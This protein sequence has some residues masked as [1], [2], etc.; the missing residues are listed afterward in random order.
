MK[1]FLLIFLLVNISSYAEKCLICMIGN[2]RGT[3]IAWQSFR[4]QVLIPLDADLALCFGQ[5][6]KHKNS[7]YKTAKYLWEIPEYTN[8]ADVFNQA[9]EKYQ[10]KKDWTIAVDATRRSALWGGI[11]HKNKS[12]RG[13]GAVVMA[14]RHILKN[15]ILDNGLLKKYD[16]FIITRS[17]YYYELAH[18]KL[19]NL[20]PNFIWIP[21]GEDYEGI[22]DRHAVVSKEHVIDFLSTL[23]HLV[24]HPESFIP[25]LNEYINIERM[26]LIHFQM[27]GLDKKI[28]RYDPISYLIKSENDHSRYSGNNIYLPKLSKPGKPKIFCKY[29]DE[30]DNA[31]KTK[32][33]LQ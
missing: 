25:F 31:Q 28:K 32:N 7:L 24:Q 17:D 5:V 29:K 11:I 33:T 2:A 6:K 20:D 12:I 30:Y 3:E 26:L 13:S 10:S 8:W 1:S 22:T 4:E 14:F 9:K 15:C 23:D 19:E 16:R 27:L 21:E 18:P